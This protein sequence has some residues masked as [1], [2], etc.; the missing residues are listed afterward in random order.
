MLV[1]QS[2]VSLSVPSKCDSDCMWYCM[3]SSGDRQSPVKSHDAYIIGSQPILT[4]LSD[5]KL[6]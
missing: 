3:A 5:T 4:E 2:Y 6:F 1:K